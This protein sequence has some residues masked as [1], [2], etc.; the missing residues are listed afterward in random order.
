MKI[1]RCFILWLVF[2]SNTLLADE[3][4]L[5]T[6]EKL[7]SKI[8][9]SMLSPFYVSPDGKH[10]AYKVGAGRYFPPLDE[11]NMESW[12]SQVI[13]IDGKRGK[14]NNGVNVFLFSPDSKRYGYISYH[15]SGNQFVV[16]DGIEGEY[17]GSKGKTDDNRQIRDIYQ[18]T[19]S[20][21]S[22]SYAYVAASGSTD[23]SSYIVLNGKKQK[24]YKSVSGPTFSP[25]STKLAYCAEATEKGKK[26]EGRSLV[27]INGQEGKK[28]HDVSCDYPNPF[29][30][31]RD[32]LH[33]AYIASKNHS[34]GQ[35][36]KCFLIIDGN[37]HDLCIDPRKVIFKK[38]GHYSINT[39]QSQ[40]KI[41]Q[42]TTK[43]SNSYLTDVEVESK[44]YD[45]SVGYTSSPDT[46]ITAYAARKKNKWI[47]VVN[48]K[49]S[50]K[51]DFVFARDATYRSESLSPIGVS[52]LHFDSNQKL[53]YLAVRGNK[54]YSVETTISQK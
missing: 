50:R 11:S 48:G 45:A 39:P 47:V 40:T 28:Y 41:P 44:K 15:H 30:F 53:R 18:L 32:S 46:K 52:S 43:V 19:F 20:P 2:T 31:S 33:Y 5:V 3:I 21:D 9:P 10:V 12:E 36:E 25:D 16:I 17:F 37:E 7:H 4:K 22:N 29:A 54:I 34:N 26:N 42:K 14:P 23:G 6:T 35:Q 38:D 1:I 51:Y 27:V 8:L 49:E 13:V 24:T